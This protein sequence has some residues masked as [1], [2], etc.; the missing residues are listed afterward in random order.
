LAAYDSAGK[1]RW[2]KDTFPGAIHKL[3]VGDLDDDGKVETLAYLSTEKLHRINGDGRERPVADITAAQ[4][5]YCQQRCGGG[6]ITTIGVWGRGE[7]KNKE[8]VAWA[9]GMFRVQKDG[10]TIL[11]LNKMQHPAG[12]GLLLNLYP[13]EPEVLATV[14]MYTLFL[15]SSRTDDKGNY[16]LLG[17]KP[18]TGPDSG[19]TLGLDFVRGVDV[20][21]F[22]GVVAA[23]E[24]EV[25]CFPISS[26]LP[27]SKD[28]GWRFSTGGAP[29]VSALVEDFDG[30]GMPE[31]LLGRQDGFVNVFKLS[32]GSLVA[33][34]GTGQ[35]IVGMA[36]LKGK[37]GKPRLAVGTRFGVHLFAADSS[38]K[39][40][41]RKLGSQGMPV[42]A[43]AG[44]GGKNKDR[45]Y[46]VDPSGQVTILKLKKDSF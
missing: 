10:T 23:I 16:T 17:Y 30:D 22:K 1:R 28:E 43:F 45:V 6:N 8:V 18:M 3:A 15:Y 31:V 34:P 35:P 36:M 25:A 42:A 39:D 5:K 2:L 40:G 38:S 29:A 46:V 21:G 44:P 37:G 32:D 12:C 9:E 20:A 7:P 26:F 33:L 19:Q 41:F 24:G 14:Y 27:N 11:E 4:L 13:N